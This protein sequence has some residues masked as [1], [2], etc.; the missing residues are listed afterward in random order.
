[1]FQNV[2]AGSTVPTKALGPLINPNIRP[3]RM[4]PFIEPNGSLLGCSLLIALNGRS[5]RP[6]PL[7]D[8]GGSPPGLGPLIDPN[9]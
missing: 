3:P 9:G 7:I 6:G 1:M 5:L 8:P 2:C 4:G